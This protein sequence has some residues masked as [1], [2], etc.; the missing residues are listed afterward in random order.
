MQIEGL[1]HL[2]GE[3]ETFGDKG[4]QKR[5]LVIETQEQYKQTIPIDFVQEKT[6][7]LEFFSVGQSVKVSINARGNENAGRYY[8][9]LNGWRIE[10]A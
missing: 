4:F 9:S 10:K 3:T 7:L 1:I 6:G 8:V 2:I 5:Q